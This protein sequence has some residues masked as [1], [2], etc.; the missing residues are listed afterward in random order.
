MRKLLRF[1]QMI[2]APVAPEPPPPANP[3]PGEKLLEQ[4]LLHAKDGY[5]NSQEVI[6]FVDTKTAVITGLNTLIGG[7]LVALLKWSIES[8]EDSHATLPELASFHPCTDA[9]SFFLVDGLLI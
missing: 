1:L 2:F 6:K 5:E 8:E 7:S 4:T 3:H 9:C